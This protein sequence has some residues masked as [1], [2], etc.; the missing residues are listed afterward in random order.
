MRRS[1]AA[2]CYAL[3]PL[4][5]HVLSL[6]L[7]FILSQDQTLHCKNCLFFQPLT[8]LHRAPRPAGS[9]THAI[10]CFQNFKVLLLSPETPSGTPRFCR[11]R[12]QRYD[13]FSNWQNFFSQKSIV[14]NAIRCAPHVC[15]MKLFFKTTILCPRQGPQNKKKQLEFSKNR[16]I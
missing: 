5:L 15:I 4:D 2:Y 10:S 12:V 8:R 9:P 13:L 6:P 3:L 14:K 1:P 11:K 7:A 16:P